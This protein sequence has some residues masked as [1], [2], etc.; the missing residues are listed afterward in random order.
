M[1]AIRIAA[2]GGPDVLQLTDLPVPEP[3]AGETLVRVTTAGVN[4]MDLYQRSGLMP[5]ALPFTAGIEG[6]GVVEKSDGPLAPGTR[7]MWPSHPGAF[8]EFACVP[9]WKLIPLPAGLDDHTA[10]AACLQGLTAQFLTESTYAVKCDDDVLVH[11]GAGGVGQLLIQ[12]LKHKGAR[13]FTTVS[14]EEKAAI[15]RAA[16]A[17]VVIRYTDEDFVAVVREQT[18]GRGVHVAYDSVGLTT[19]AGSLSL[20]R[21]LGTLVLF[22]QSSGVVP[23]IDPLL[24]MRQGSIFLTR[25]TLIHH[26]ADASAVQTRSARL[27]EWLQAGILRPQIGGLYPLAE[28]ARAQTDLASRRTT[29]KL[30]IRV[31]T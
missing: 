13:V 4:F 8:A 5:M 26:I 29:G 20:V 31:A 2:H 17:D 10:V 3:K 18:R 12:V 14:T 28:T 24:L 7:V 22:G 21:P 19:H 1:K 6:V 16:G 9:T 15:A 23:P 11:A 25:P 30:L 27:L